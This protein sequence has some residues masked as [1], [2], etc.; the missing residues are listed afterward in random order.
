MGSITNLLDLRIKAMRRMVI[1]GAMAVALVPG[2]ALATASFDAGAFFQFTNIT[3][4]DGVVL[5]F[6]VDDSI[7]NIGPNVG[8]GII[9]EASSLPL[10]GGDTDLAG[11]TPQTVRVT[12]SAYPTLGG[13]SYSADAYNF[14]TVTAINTNSTGGTLDVVFD[15]IYGLDALT[16]L[17][18]FLLENVGASVTLFMD[19]VIGGVGQGQAIV[20]ET[21]DLLTAGED[22][23]FNQGSFTLSLSPGELNGVF[24]ELFTE[25]LALSRGEE[26]PGVPVPATLA[27]LG[28]GLIGLASRKRRV[29]A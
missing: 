23:I 19:A 4:P 22:F 13:S 5:S 14:A 1:A 25:G 3:A 6:S 28:I 7:V 9:D 24:V 10:S 8:D 17:D 29:V 27:L 11:I 15:F 16:S 12:G 21:I 26:T 2:S 20:D 18:D